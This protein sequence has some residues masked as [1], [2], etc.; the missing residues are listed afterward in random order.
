MLLVCC[1]GPVE[2]WQTILFDHHRMSA[3]QVR[4]IK[5]TASIRD[6]SDTIQTKVFGSQNKNRVYRELGM[7]IILEQIV[8]IQG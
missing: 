5:K 3:N 2:I 4:S 6:I 7:L 8:Q 1:F